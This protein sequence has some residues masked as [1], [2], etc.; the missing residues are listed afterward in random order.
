MQRYFPTLTYRHLTLISCLSGAIVLGSADSSYARNG[1]IPHYVGIE[2]MIGGAG[3]AFPLDATSTIANPAALGRLPSHVLFNIGGIYQDQHVDTSKAIIGNPVGK[4]RNGYN[5]IFPLTFGFNVRLNEQWAVGFAATGGGGF[6]K[7]DKPITNPA[8]LVPAGSDFNKKTVNSVTLT[9]TT[10]TYSPTPTQTYGISALVASST[11]QSDMMMNDGTQVTGALSKDRVFGFGV[12]IGGIWD[13]NKHITLGASVATPVYCHEHENY[14]QLFANDKFQIPATAR[15]GVTW[16]ISSATDF[17]FDLKELFYGGAKW[18][19]NG[20][21]WRN[22]FI[23]LTG[24]MHRFTE[25][26][27]AGIGYNYA[28]APFKEDRVVFNTLSI[29][30]DEHHI[31]GGLRYILDN[32]KTEFFVMGYYIP[33]KKM[34]DNGQGPFGGASQGIEIENASSGFEVGIKYNF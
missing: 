32:K 27:S 5:F 13:L 8:M 26:F 25:N 16:H 9:A 20:Q 1:F 15:L 11:F 24:V 33:R 23:V 7:F 19:N 2:G 17:S 29:P 12:R 10:L 4:Q 31:S 28:K 30:L 21:G 18:V 14:K 3:T 6:V 34:T 22:Q